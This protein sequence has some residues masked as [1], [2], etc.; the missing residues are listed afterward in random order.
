M[1]T[2]PHQFP[3]QLEI[4]LLLLLFSQLI[5]FQL[6]AMPRTT[7]CQIPLSLGF[8]RQEYWRGLPF[9]S[10]WDFGVGSIQGLNLYLLVSCIDRKILYH[11]ATWEA[12]S[13]A[14]QKLLGLTR[15]HLFIFGFIFITLRGGL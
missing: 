12:P 14:V 11:C 9:P 13:F 8:P 4:I 5:Y 6:F 10:P 2:T 7:V 3:W 15:S 1:A